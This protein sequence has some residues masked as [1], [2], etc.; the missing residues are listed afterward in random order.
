MFQFRVNTSSVYQYCR[1]C[2]ISSSEQPKK[3]LGQL[4]TV[5]ES[6]T[7]FPAIWDSLGQ[8]AE[9]HGPY[10]TQLTDLDSLN[11]RHNYIFKCFYG[12][13]NQPLLTFSYI[14]FLYSKVMFTHLETLIF[15]ACCTVHCTVY[16]AG[17]CLQSWACYIF[18]N[19]ATSDNASTNSFKDSAP[20]SQT[21]VLYTIFIVIV[22]VTIVGP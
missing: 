20:Q 21:E 13:L 4:A 9:Q 3:V 5:L 2:S 12:L 11:V 1:Y 18:F 22:I 19:A 10:L 7:Q 15:T 6:P 16:Q 14:P 8:L 17:Y